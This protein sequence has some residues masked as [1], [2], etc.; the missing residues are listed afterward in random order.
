MTALM[1]LSWLLRRR[2]STLR[3]HAAAMAALARVVR[4]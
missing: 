2:R 1:P 4:R 3:V